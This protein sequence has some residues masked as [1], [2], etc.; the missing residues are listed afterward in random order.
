MARRTEEIVR[1][2]KTLQMNTPD[3]EASAVVSV[4]GLLIASTLPA[5]VAEERVAALSAAMHSLGKRLASALKRGVLD[6]VVVRGEEGYVVLVSIGEKAV[7]TALALSRAKL[8][9]IFLEMN[10]TANELVTL[11]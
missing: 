1:H 4:E 5:E 7:L 2:L 8:G 9:L 10:R 6:Q 11:V 3:I